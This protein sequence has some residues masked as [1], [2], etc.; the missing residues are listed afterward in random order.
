MDPTSHD[1]A[2]TAVQD[3][4]SALAIGALNG[5][6][7]A[8][9]L[10]H[11][12]GC[13]RC[14]AELEELSAAADALLT[15]IPEATPPAGFAARTTARMHAEGGSKRR[16]VVW[17]ALAVAAVVVGLALGFGINAIN[18]S[19]GGNSTA[20]RTS[21]L[22][23]TTG[24]QGSVLVSSGPNAWLDMTVRDAPTSGTV[25]C[26]VTLADGR[27]QVVGRFSLSEGYGA[28]GARLRV[29]PSSI[30]T[31]SVVDQSGSTIAWAHLSS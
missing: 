30:R 23:S 29:P 15:L 13:T 16:P 18:S 26:A 22:H 21:A 4:L 12:E 5:R 6:E 28:W 10:A 9:V 25:T 31:V 7:R 11:L 20:V 17:R 24:A 8:I 2:C 19:P 3:D 14:T 1:A 27:R